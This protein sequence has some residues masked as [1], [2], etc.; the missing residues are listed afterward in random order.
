MREGKGEEGAGAGGKENPP[1]R[2]APGGGVLGAEGATSSLSC[3]VRSVLA[4]LTMVR[5]VA[6]A[7]GRAPEPHRRTG[8]HGAGDEVSVAVAF[9]CFR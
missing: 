4:A 1:G 7:T 3:A 5:G 8:A 6:A 9:L 2:R